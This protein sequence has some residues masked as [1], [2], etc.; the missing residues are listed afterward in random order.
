LDGRGHGKQFN[1]VR[2]DEGYTR[3][4]FARRSR[5]KAI[6]GGFID[7]PPGGELIDLRNKFVLPGLINCH[8]HLTAQL[9][10]G[11]RLRSVE[12]SDPKVGFNA[13]HNAAVTLGAG[14]TTVRDVGAVGNP[15][16][17]FALRAAVAERKF[18]GPRI[19]CLGAVLSPT[20]GH[21]QTYGYRHDVCACVQSTSGICDG[22]GPCC[23]DQPVDALPLRNVVTAI[24]IGLEWQ[25]GHLRGV[26]GGSTL[27]SG[28]ARPDLPPVEAWGESNLAQRPTNPG[29]RTENGS[30][31][32]PPQDAQPS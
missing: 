13:A 16:I 32:Y 25:G 29:H 22:V 19:L 17:I 11:S 2:E 26:D 23:M 6:S 27:L 8:V 24:G 3:W 18:P 10:R 15:E 31:R 14:F 5:H 1:K 9:D 4:L 12:D 28:T 20:G 30:L 7:P 21:G